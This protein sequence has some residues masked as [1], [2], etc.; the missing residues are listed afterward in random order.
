MGALVSRLVRRTQPQPGEALAIDWSN[1]LTRDMTVCLMH[2]DQAYGFVSAT[3]GSGFPVTQNNVVYTAGVQANTVQGTGGRPIG[4]TPMYTLA[5]KGAIDSPNYSLFA[6]GT[7]TSTSATQSALDMDNSSERYW[8]FR[9]NAGKVEFLPFNASMTA[10]TGQVT[11]PVALTV[12]EMSRGF[13]MGAT[14]S[15]TRTACFQ[16]GVITVGAPSS[17]KTPGIGIP[18]CVGARATNAQQWGTGALMLVVVWRRTLADSEMQALADNPWQLFAARRRRMWMSPTAFAAYV[19]QAAV[20]TF[21]MSASQVA[22]SAARRLVAAAGAL[23]SSWSPA[24]L[25]AW[26]RLTA[27][28]G[29]FAMN[30]SSAPILAAR[31]LAANVG[32]FGLL[33][34]A[35]PM[36]TVR[37]LTLQSGA[38]A[39]SPGAVQMTYTPAQGSGGPTYT[40]MAVAGAFAL[41]AGAANV[42]ARRRLGA[43]SCPF[44]WSGAAAPVLV[45]RRMSTSTGMFA[46]ASGSVIMRAARCVLTQVGTFGLSGAD[47][48]LR[49]SAQVTYARAPVGRGYIPQ[50]HYNESRPAE[51]NMS[52]P[53]ELQ[54][55]HR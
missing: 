33:G 44:A 37:R 25:V 52:R 21:Q 1:P 11:S 35:V 29:A 51:S 16:N 27:G 23:T 24:N 34:A 40:L 36:I 31:K 32:T 47:A 48:Q 2:A 39:L 8:Q 22:L 43:A 7:C 17:M 4:T 15:P 54:R 28:A 38:F 53:A 26:R 45:G 3:D 49:Y 19:L 50:Q 9:L 6:F 20:G 18:I 41:T 55:N 5:A 14:A 10:L 46:V 12:A 42:L 30:G 13:T